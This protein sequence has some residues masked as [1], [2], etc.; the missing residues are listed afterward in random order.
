M[1]DLSKLELKRLVRSESGNWIC[2]RHGKG[3]E[4]MGLGVILA[5]TLQ[6]RLNPL[7]TY[8]FVK[9]LSNGVWTEQDKLRSGLQHTGACKWCGQIDTFRHHLLDCPRHACRN[10]V[11]LS[12]GTGEVLNALCATGVGGTRFW[13]LAD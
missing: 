4:G 11:S 10:G 7:Q 5:R 1:Q 9:F 2:K 3:E 6:R 8:M 12:G 13:P